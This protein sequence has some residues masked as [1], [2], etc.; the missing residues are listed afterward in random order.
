M[1]TRYMA[2]MLLTVFFAFMI[3]IS[4]F[5]DDLYRMTLPGVVVGKPKMEKGVKEITL[6]DGTIIEQSYAMLTVP[7]GAVKEAITETGEPKAVVFLLME[8]ENGYYVTEQAV[9]IEKKSDGSVEITEGLKKKDVVVFASDRDFVTEEQ[10]KIV[11]ENEQVRLHMMRQKKEGADV[12]SPY[13]K[14]CMHRNVIVG[15]ILLV[16]SVVLLVVWKKCIPERFSFFGYIVAVVWCV[17]VC[18]CIKEFIVIPSEWIPRRLI[19]FSAWIENV[20]KYPI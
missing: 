3:S 4:L 14:K 7:A 17:L 8:T 18:V 15:V 16:V 9:G 12:T 10:V 2:N 5:A 11:E 20:R 6:E 1:R 19:D 13:L